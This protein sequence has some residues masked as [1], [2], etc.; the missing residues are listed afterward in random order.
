MSDGDSH[1]LPI[2]QSEGEAPVARESERR[3]A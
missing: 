1:N 3:R 2:H